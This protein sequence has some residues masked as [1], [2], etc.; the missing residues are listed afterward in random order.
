MAEQAEQKN[1]TR[2]KR[3]TEEEAREVLREWRE[4]GLSVAAFARRRGI[5]AMRIPYW[6]QRLSSSADVNFVAVP[7]PSATVELEY[8]GV[9]VRIRELGAEELARLVVAIARRA[10]EC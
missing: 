6:D 1:G 8:Q 9:V 4:S 2:A 5:S 10:R 7:L 3:W